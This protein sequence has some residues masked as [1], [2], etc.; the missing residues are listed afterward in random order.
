[1][2][3][4]KVKHRSWFKSIA[5]AVVC[6][7]TVHGLTWAHPGF[8]RDHQG[9]PALQVQS[10]FKPILDVTGHQ[11]DTQIRVELA[12][13]LTMALKN[14]VPAFQDINSEL[15]KWLSD[16]AG[17]NKKRL[18]DVVSN[19]IKKQ[20]KTII[21][22]RLFDELHMQRKFRIVSSCK[23][24]TDIQHDESKIDIEIIT[25]DQRGYEREGSFGYREGGREGLENE[26]KAREEAAVS[27]ESQLR[28]RD[29]QMYPSVVAHL[30]ELFGGN[31]NGKKV[32]ELG[33]G[34]SPGNILALKS[35]GAQV[36]AVDIDETSLKRL[37]TLLLKAGADDVK[38]IEMDFNG[39]FQLESEQ[40]DAI[41]FRNILDFVPDGIDHLGHAEQDI[42]VRAHAH[43]KARKF[44]FS[45]CARVL[46]DGGVVVAEDVAEPAY[47]YESTVLSDMLRTFHDIADIGKAAQEAGFRIVVRNRS[48]DDTLLILLH[49]RPSIKKG[50]VS[51]TSSQIEGYS[52]TEYPYNETYPRQLIKIMSSRENTDGMVVAELGCGQGQLARWVSG[53]GFPVIGLDINPANIKVAEQNTIDEGMQLVRG[54]SAWEKVKKLSSADHPA[55]AFQ[56]CDLAH[57]IP[58]PDGSVDAIILHRTL[59]QIIKNQDREYLLEEI[60]RVLK[61]GGYVSYLDFSDLYPQGLDGR[62]DFQKEV[63]RRLLRDG[64]LPS[65]LRGFMGD[66][67][68][69]PVLVYQH[70]QGPTKNESEYAD[71][72][73]L[74]TDIKSGRVKVVFIGI[75]ERDRS[76]KARFTRL[77]FSGF[78]AQEVFI[79]RKENR[80]ARL[81]GFVAQKPPGISAVPE[82]GKKARVEMVSPDKTMARVIDSHGDRHKV[83]LSGGGQLDLRVLSES[84][85]GL[86]EIAGKPENYSD[87]VGPMLSAVTA[88]D[89]T[90]HIFRSLVEDLFAFCSPEN[91][92]MAFYKDIP[93]DPVA[94]FHEIGEYLISTGMMQL[95]MVDGCLEIVLPGRDPATLVPSIDTMEFITGE[96][97]GESWQEEPHYLLRVLQKE[98]FGTFDTKFSEYIQTH[99]QQM[100]LSQT[101]EETSE[102]PAS[103][104][105]DTTVVIGSRKMPFK[106]PESETRKRSTRRESSRYVAFDQDEAKGAKRGP[107]DTNTLESLF[108]RGLMMYGDKMYF[109]A[110]PGLK[111]DDKGNIRM[112][113]EARVIKGDL[114][115]VSRDLSDGNVETIQQIFYQIAEIKLRA[116]KA[117]EKGQDAYKEVLME[118]AEDLR[119]EVNKVL[120]DH[121][122]DYQMEKYKPGDTGIMLSEDIQ[123]LLEERTEKLIVASNITRLE[124]RVAM[125]KREQRTVI[126]KDGVPVEPGVPFRVTVSSGGSIEYRKD[127]PGDPVELILDPESDTLEVAGDD[128]H[129]YVMNAVLEYNSRHGKGRS[130]GSRIV[131]TEGMS[132]SRKSDYYS[133]ISLIDDVPVNISDPGQSE[134]L[135]KGMALLGRMEENGVTVGGRKIQLMIDRRTGLSGVVVQIVLEKVL[136]DCGGR[137]DMMPERMTIA[138]LDRSPYLFED[139][140]SN[141]FIGINRFVLA[142]KDENIRTR[143]LLTGLYHELSHEMTGRN[144]GDFEKEQ[145]S[146]DVEYC[147]G[148]MGADKQQLIRLHDSLTIV[149]DQDSGFLEELGRAADPHAI[150]VFQSELDRAFIDLWISLHEVERVIP[151]ALSGITNE[152]IMN[153]REAKKLVKFNLPRY[154]RETIEKAL[155]L[156]DFISSEF[157]EGFRLAQ[158]SSGQQAFE[159]KIDSVRGSFFATIDTL[160][161]ML[162]EERPQGLEE[163]SPGIGRRAKVVRIENDRR[164]A[165]V[166]GTDRKERKVELELQDAGFLLE[167]KERVNVMQ[168]LPENSQAGFEAIIRLF[169]A[170]SPDIGVFEET[171]E[172][173]FAFAKPNDNIIAFHRYLAD[174]PPAV[175]HEI[176]EYLVKMGEL[177]IRYTGRLAELTNRVG[178]CGFLNEVLGWTG[179]FEGEAQLLTAEGAVLCSVKLRK[180]ALSIA[181]KDTSDP[182]YMIRAFLRAVLGDADRDLT[183]KIKS[184][185]RA[186]MENILDEYPQTNFEGYKLLGV[187][188][189][190][191]LADEMR[192]L[193]GVGF[194][195]CA[196]GVYSPLQ[197]NRLGLHF[198]RA[199]AV[200]VKDVALGLKEDA[201]DDIRILVVGSGTGIDA[202]AASHHARKI[203]FGKVHVDAIDINSRGIDNLRKNLHLAGEEYQSTIFPRLV[204]QGSEFENLQD[205][206]DLILFNAPDAV[207]FEDASEEVIQRTD[208]A[209][210]MDEGVF[211]SIMRKI[212]TRLSAQGA[213][214]VS[215]HS[216]VYEKQDIFPDN[217]SVVAETFGG[218]AILGGEYF[219]RVL[220]H[221][222]P[223]NKPVP[224]VFL[225]GLIGA[226][227]ERRL[228]QLNG[229]VMPRI[230]SVRA[231][232]EHIA[233][234]L[235]HE[236]LR[237]ADSKDYVVLQLKVSYPD[238]DVYRIIVDKPSFL[239]NDID[240]IVR[241]DVVML[242]RFDLVF[243]FAVYP[244]LDTVFVHNISSGS[245]VG[246][247]S[248][249]RLRGKGV[250]SELFTNFA[251]EIKDKYP[252]WHVSSYLLDKSGALQHL[253]GKHFRMIEAD[254]ER[255]GFI[256]L[257]KQF[258]VIAGVEDAEK[259]F[260][261]EAVDAYREFDQEQETVKPGEDK[262]KADDPERRQRLLEAKMNKSSRISLRLLRIVKECLAGAD[263]LSR[264]TEV[265]IVVDLALIPEE[266]LQESAETWSYLIRSCDQ[267]RGVNFIFEKKLRTTREELPLDLAG[268]MEQAA[269][270]EDFIDRLEQYLG[271]GLMARVNRP[272]RESAIEI[273]ILSKRMLE[274]ERDC[275]ID[276]RH[277][278]YPVA[279]IGPGITESGETALHNFGAAL[280]IGLC[281]VGLVVAKMSDEA[282]GPEE[283]KDYPRV[284]KKMLDELKKLYSLFR[285]D[286]ILTEKTVN[287]MVHPV[288][289]V[290]MN[291]AI[292]LALPPITRMILTEL[293]LQHDKLQLF[294][295]AA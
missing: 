204:K 188:T 48:F 31:L 259:I 134:E 289:A 239:L 113:V 163:G 21:E 77:G 88:S 130:K 266:D 73:E 89:V 11:Y 116:R 175:V 198:A 271:K 234:A 40:Y 60:E 245:T 99:Q 44:F 155:Q 263:Q 168:N 53:K 140:L 295:I 243:D 156:V 270:A 52:G 182:H 104:K 112:N 250:M 28:S 281:K 7:L 216:T 262:G 157:E 42:R 94:Q 240:F 193:T 90:V 39:I 122:I 74:Y 64:L 33:A 214:L 256:G 76:V 201:R 1:M 260:V 129:K 75:H 293:K 194:L 185:Y 212:G 71:P 284:R 145:L 172:D 179:L 149:L 142:L 202:M 251:N 187:D 219:G 242:N 173:L 91:K 226:R 144:D 114:I 184:Y 15:D 105:E 178:L 24:I 54:R 49:E 292:T 17:V 253:F 111:F 115:E 257:I 205:S 45:E 61:P 38:L 231:D 189:Q 241:R 181:H 100:Q 4:F 221:M 18:L 176:M 190:R 268:Q 210:K 26:E 290:R 124:E 120:K 287:N 152:L 150:Q 141:G 235:L 207:S 81:G 165:I 25:Q 276:L 206:Y 68:I 47:D 244:D 82:I 83:E 191:G 27:G 267:M 103:S 255:E 249:S 29:D 20:G 230:L 132:I 109:N 5:V 37:R 229:G 55:N 57:G 9:T 135:A 265:D 161:G 196:E 67:Q 86:A 30:K 200:K 282:K 139:G 258:S 247:E 6:L 277:N 280:A 59:S 252:G 143:L 232:S 186:N 93:G 222:T 138:M 294:L 246:G 224:E 254:H 84:L 16:V 162:D 51:V 274:W 227:F 147:T 218:G 275:D 85:K 8:V 283:E 288:S 211:R 233:S 102:R 192:Q 133:P 146:R 69:T 209:I 159:K 43:F 269:E 106:G 148:I 128:A 217:L 66:A 19:P 63:I 264:L 285:K 35:E 121:N 110:N 126:F 199:V 96:A 34:S 125:L 225:R 203:G 23:S 79:K 95:N 14:E 136:E 97:W 58:L 169:E 278:Q 151:E 56:Q 70:L 36:D 46:K 12:C 291:L 223:V 273:P 62:Y 72:Q 160:N 41:I 177:K 279:L 208:H 195:A 117:V 213:A 167:L 220:F 22:V 123:Q 131:H 215:N 166:I 236:R 78:T 119:L 10:I 158:R 50:A 65:V 171:V 228:T 98:L 272:R 164:V 32:L 183:E 197:D 107:M 127:K 80:Y 13:I 137:I 238:R 153:L 170:T 174:N 2:N 248:F 261:G 118:Q 108:R 286:I 101:A 154:R 92:M 180:D 3:S 87:I 237:Y